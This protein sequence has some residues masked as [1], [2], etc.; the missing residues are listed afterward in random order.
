MTLAML[1]SASAPPIL[2][3]VVSASLQIL[4]PG[5]IRFDDLLINVDRDGQDDFDIYPQ[6]MNWQ[7]A[8]MRTEVVGTFAIRLGGPRPPMAA[9]PVSRWHWYRWPERRASG[10]AGDRST[11]CLL[12]DETQRP[13]AP[14]ISAIARCS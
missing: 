9:T 13:A 14:R 2:G 7:M 12:V 4:E 5:E 3:N 8:C 1:F 6:P 11:S 10:L